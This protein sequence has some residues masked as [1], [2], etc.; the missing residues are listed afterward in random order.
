MSNKTIIA[1]TA[2]TVL[3]SA[4]ASAAFAYEDPENKIGDRYPFLEQTYQSNTSSRAAS[5]R[6]SAPRSV[7]PAWAFNLNQ[8][9]NANQYANDV[10]ENKIGDRYP[11]LEPKIQSL[12]VRGHVTAGRH[13]KN[14]MKSAT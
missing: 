2:A 1:L 13:H 3:A 5:A 4:S 12:R 7:M 11:L 14:S 8:F 10:P 6:I 9:S